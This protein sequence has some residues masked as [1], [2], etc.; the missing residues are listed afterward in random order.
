MEAGEGGRRSPNRK[1]ASWTARILAP[2][3]LLIAVAAIVLVVTGSL[4]SSDDD[5]RGGDRRAEVTSGCQPDAENAVEDGYY[6][7]EVGE[8]LSV[9]ADRTCIPIERLMRLN[10]NL[11]PQL[12]QV[13]SCVDLRFEGCKALAE[14]NG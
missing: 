6:V 10:E 11:D 9:V 7:I 12:I 4:D 3:A 8:D 14:G 5:D 2:L 1:P 13:G